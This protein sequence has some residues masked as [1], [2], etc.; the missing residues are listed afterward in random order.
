MS[1]LVRVP[2]ATKAA[3][4]ELARLRNESQGDI[5]AAAIDEMRRRTVIEAANEA[6]LE[7][8]GDKAA[9]QAFERESAGWE[10][11]GAADSEEY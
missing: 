9:F 10:R 3:I 5:V 4:D 1:S 6:Y 11:A 2:D 7:F 8:R